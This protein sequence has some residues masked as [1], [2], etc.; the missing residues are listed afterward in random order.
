MKYIYDV[1]VPIIKRFAKI[2]NKELRF[3]IKHDLKRQIYNLFLS[4][5]NILPTSIYF[6]PGSYCP[7]RCQDCYVSVEDRKQNIQ[8]SESV[9]SQITTFARNEKISNVAVF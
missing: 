2:N 4:H 5:E 1:N 3:N 7:N 6:E 8:L 9:I